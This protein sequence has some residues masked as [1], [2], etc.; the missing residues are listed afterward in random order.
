MITSCPSTK[1]NH[2][3][4]AKCVYKFHQKLNQIQDPGDVPVDVRLHRRLPAQ[5]GRLPRGQV[6]R[7]Y[8]AGMMTYITVGIRLDLWGT[9]VWR[10]KVILSNN[11]C[12]WIWVPTVVSGHSW[13]TLAAPSSS[14]STTMDPGAPHWSKKLIMQSSG[15]TLLTSLNIRFKS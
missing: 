8:W 11:H 12:S 7:T 5:E 6:P 15:A 1:Q 13:S 4:T 9:I 3:K 10:E 2:S 14:S